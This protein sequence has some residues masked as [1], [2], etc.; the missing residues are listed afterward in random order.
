MRSSCGTGV[1]IAGTTNTR[2]RLTSTIAIERRKL[3]LSAPD[4]TMSRTIVYL[5]RWLSVTFAALTA[6]G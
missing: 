1:V 6:T 2:P 3:S 5:L 4:V